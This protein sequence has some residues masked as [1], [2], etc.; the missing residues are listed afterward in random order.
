MS[1]EFVSIPVQ[2]VISTTSDWTTF[3][4]V[5]GGWWSN[6]EIE[7]LKGLDR[8]R[9][10]VLFSEKTIRISKAPLDT[11]S[12]EVKAKCT[13][14]INKKYLDSY[15]SYLITKGD[16]QSTSV[17]IIIQGKEIQ[18]LEN[19]VKIAGNPY[20]PMPFNVSADLHV[21]AFQRRAKESISEK[22]NEADLV[23]VAFGK[24]FEKAFEKKNPENEDVED[25]FGWLRSH[26]KNA[27]TFLDIET[28]EK[29]AFEAETHFMK[30][31]NLRKKV[32]SESSKTLEEIKGR[33]DNLRETY[34]KLGL[35]TP[36]VSGEKEGKKVAPKE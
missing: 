16:L 11:A 5:E 4:I 6:V 35:Q 29:L 34:G 8:L 33:Y 30:F 36:F 17:R 15:I 24:N 20:N 9:E 28:Y 12:V 25:V 3:Q 23:S 10:E 31:P 26:G 7:H 2:Y 1:V 14:N 18:R 21:S 19:T 13:L 32:S 22:K 27:R